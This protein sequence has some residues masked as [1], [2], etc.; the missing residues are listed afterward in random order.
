VKMM[1]VEQNEGWMIWLARGEDRAG[2]SY[3]NVS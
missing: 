1:P 3:A 2:N